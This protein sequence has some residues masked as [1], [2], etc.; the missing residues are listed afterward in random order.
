MK[1]HDLGIEESKFYGDAAVPAS[2]KTQK[3]IIRPNIELL[4]SQFPELKGADLNDHFTIEADVRVTMVE[5]REGKERYRLEFIRM[6]KK[7]GKLSEDEFEKLP[8]Q[9]Q[10]E[11]MRKSID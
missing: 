1:K 10:R 2:S 7:G 4:L 8:A 11:Y 6:G 9:K 5:K 3:K